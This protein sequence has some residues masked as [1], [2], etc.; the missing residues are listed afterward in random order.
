MAKRIP[1]AD[2]A[3][4]APG[5]P[6]AVAP[7]LLAAGMDLTL[8]K[9]RVFLQGAGALTASSLLGRHSIADRAIHEATGRTSRRR[10]I[11]PCL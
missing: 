5:L 11:V 7:Y 8:L 2:H 10:L 9:G 6:L 3:H 4:L 1:A